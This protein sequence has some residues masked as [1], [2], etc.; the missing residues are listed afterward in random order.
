MPNNNPDSLV[1]NGY[2]DMYDALGWRAASMAVDSSSDPNASLCSVL[3]WMQQKLGSQTLA[4]EVFQEV[5]Q[6]YELLEKCRG[7]LYG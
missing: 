5:E 3:N 1:T 6:D 2:W 4:I 7:E